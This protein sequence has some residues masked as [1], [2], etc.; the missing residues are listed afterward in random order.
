M[1]DGT[2]VADRTTLAARDGAT[3]KAAEW[4]CPLLGGRPIL[5]S[6][7]ESRRAERNLGGGYLWTACAACPMNPA[8][9]TS[10]LEGE[11]GGRAKPDGRVR[12][13]TPEPS[14][15]APPAASPAKAEAVAAG[16]CRFHP[17]RPALSARID[18]CGSCHNRW[19]REGR[20]AEPSPPRKLPRSAARCRFC[21]EETVTGELCAVHAQRWRRAGRPDLSAWDGGAAPP[22]PR[23]V[24]RKRPGRKPGARRAASA[25]PAAKP[26]PGRLEPPPP[27]PRDARDLT[28]AEAYAIAVVHARDLTPAEHDA[29]WGRAHRYEA[30]LAEVRMAATLEEARRIAERAVLGEREGG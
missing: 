6:A 15:P 1:I 10:P 12:G 11:V 27:P 9:F 8:L 2:G 30:A 17:D 5:R 20:P 24:G 4:P 13:K 28:F 25:P 29:L 21:G 22:K 3:P 16:R 26:A 14:P 23:A 18:L 7:C 19:S